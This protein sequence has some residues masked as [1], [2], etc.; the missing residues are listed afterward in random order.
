MAAQWFMPGIGAPF[1]GGMIDEDGADEW[2][3]PG[4]GY[5]NED[6][7]AAGGATLPIFDNHYRSMRAA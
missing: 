1:S 6:Q 7:A 3:V 5:L 4:V 2:F